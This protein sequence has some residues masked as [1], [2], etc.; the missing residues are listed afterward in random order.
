MICAVSS[1]DR[2]PSL[3]SLTAF[4]I[5]GANFIQSAEENPLKLLVCIKFLGI[6]TV[7]LDVMAE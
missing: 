7:I 6:G 3:R 4:R 2:S 1:V 5:P